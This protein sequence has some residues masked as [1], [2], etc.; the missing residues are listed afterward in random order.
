MSKNNKKQ[1][2]LTFN[3]FL[4]SLMMTLFLIVIIAGCGGGS[5][6]GDGGGGDVTPTASPTVSPTA[7]PT[8]TPTEN[9][10]VEFTI[11]DKDT[12]NPVKGVSVML[13]SSTKLT[14]GTGKVLFQ[15]IPI[16]T[17]DAQIIADGYG[18]ETMQV[19]VVQGQTV[20]EACQLTVPT[21]VEGKSNI[22]GYVVDSNG[23]PIENVK[24]TI[25][26]STSNKGKAVIKDVAATDNNGRYGFLGMDN[27]VYIISFSNLPSGI[28]PPGP[29]SVSAFG[30]NCSAPTATAGGSGGG[31]GGGGT[32]PGIIY[33]TVTDSG[34]D[35]PVPN[36]N[37]SI[38]FDFGDGKRGARALQET[39]TDE[40]GFYEFRGLTG[41]NYAVTARK[42]GI[43]LP[44]TEKVALAAGEVKQQD[45][46][47]EWKVQKAGNMLYCVWGRDANDIFAV[48]SAGA[49]KHSSNGT[50][51]VNMQSGV[52]F[53]LLGVWGPA[54]TQ[55]VYAVGYKG[56]IL[57]YFNNAWSSVNTGTTEDLYAVWGSSA[58]DIFAVGKNGTILHYDGSS[59]NQMSNPDTMKKTLSSVWGTGPDNVWAVGDWGKM[60][61][62]DGTS[63][64]EIPRITEYMLMKVWGSDAN[65]VYAVGGSWVDEIN[66]KYVILKY[67]GT[68]WSELSS[69]TGAYLSSVWGTA[70]NNVY[71]GS[72]YGGVIMH[73]LGGSNFLPM[74]T[75][76]G[77][78]LLHI[79]GTDANNIYGV[80]QSGIIVRWNGTSWTNQTG[81]VTETLWGITA[82][83]ENTAFAVGGQTALYK[84]LALKTTDGGDTWVPMVTNQPQ[85]LPILRDVWAADANNVHAVGGL[86]IIVYYDG[87]VLNTWI[88]SRVPDGITLNGIWGADA[89]RVYAVGDNGTFLVFNPLIPAWVAG[90]ATG[91]NENLQEICGFIQGAD[92]HLY[93]VGNNGKIIRSTNSGVSWSDMASPTVKNLLDIWGTSENNI[94]ACGEQNTFLHYDGTS[95]SKIENIDPN[96][97][98]YYRYYGVWGS[99]VDNIFFVGQN[100]IY[101]YDGSISREMSSGFLEPVTGVSGYVS[102]Q[103]VKVYA[104]GMSG[105]IFVHKESN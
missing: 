27:G 72:L 100:R 73:Y 42:E 65:N 79:W 47:L 50:D 4:W 61:H 9:G 88:P 80:G 45:I 98:N 40:R 28:T 60:L 58:N 10:N 19:T 94:Y 52:E 69:G 99:A 90:G 75:G 66:S 12:S 49:I 51:W 25:T 16:G 29:I 91:T 6:G 101:A 74:D 83:S 102:G 17:Y 15:N 104:T 5:S 34:D 3:F 71:M 54:S 23:I 76:T 63:W 56:T 26:K 95:W 18:S 93:A 36:A 78:G 96:P 43:Y 68:T 55:E 14:D 11:K 89:A 38:N 2:S 67:D 53:D 32:T 70:S 21:P 82:V 97:L 84:S 31:G 77:A 92:V 22:I 81:N 62:Y 103:N 8:V 7:S 39:Y 57:R 48:G 85:D 87:N 13:N 41:G 24:A 37:V 46:E 1:K 30:G 59:W 35:S 64:T 105:S 33:G 44:K 20:S 86:G